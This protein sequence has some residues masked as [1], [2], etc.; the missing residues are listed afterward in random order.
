MGTGGFFGEELDSGGVGEDLRQ[1][2]QKT[3]AG[4]WGSVRTVTG[5]KDDAEQRGADHLGK[6][7]R[8]GRSGFWAR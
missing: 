6:W 5:D 1:L 2:R 4:R 7:G 8:S 3:V